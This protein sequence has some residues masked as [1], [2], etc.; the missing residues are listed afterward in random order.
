MRRKIEEHAE[1]LE[2]FDQ[3]I[4]EFNKEYY[5]EKKILRD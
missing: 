4:A 1:R 2:Y 3:K 5:A